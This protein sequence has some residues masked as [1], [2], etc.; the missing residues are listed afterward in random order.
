MLLDQVEP[1][2]RSV[3]RLGWFAIAIGCL[4]APVIL[5]EID[6]SLHL[7]NMWPMFWMRLAQIEAWWIG[8]IILGAAFIVG[9]VLVNKLR[10]RSR[11]VWYRI[12]AVVWWLLLAT[13]PFFLTLV[14]SIFQINLWLGNPDIGLVLWD[15]LTYFAVIW[16]SGTAAFAVSTYLGFEFVFDGL[17]GGFWGA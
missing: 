10:E 15:D 5:R 12:A 3:R 2:T 9:R 6:R 17:T 7:S 16:L 4:A 1:T 13:A 14:V 11:T 8:A